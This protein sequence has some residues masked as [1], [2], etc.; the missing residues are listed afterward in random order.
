[1]TR[2]LAQDV[3]RRAVPMEDLGIPPKAIEDARARSARAPRRPSSKT[4]LGLPDSAGEIAAIRCEQRR[5]TISASSPGTV[6]S[7]HLHLHD[8][9]DPEWVTTPITHAEL[10]QRVIDRYRARQFSATPI[11]RGALDREFSANGPGRIGRGSRS[12]AADT[13]WTVDAGTILNPS[14]D[15]ARSVS[16]AGT[17]NADRAVGHVKVL[18]AQAAR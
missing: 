7:R 13:G 15:R 14:R 17:A 18:T 3:E 4:M 5:K 1:M 16:P 9:A 10:A 12:A 8:H 6:V 2:G 11:S